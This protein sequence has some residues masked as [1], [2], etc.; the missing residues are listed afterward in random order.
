MTIV[1]HFKLSLVL[2]EVEKL[3]VA[4]DAHEQFEDEAAHEDELDDVVPGAGEDWLWLSY[5][6]QCEMKKL[7][8]YNWD[9]ANQT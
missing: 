6:W 9:K 1:K 8:D 3:A 7:P 4:H 2:E 5:L